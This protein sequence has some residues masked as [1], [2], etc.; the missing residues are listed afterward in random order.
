V[1]SEFV[2]A[3]V[4][5]ANEWVEA[6][7]F[8]SVALREGGAVEV[9]VPYK[10]NVPGGAPQMSDNLGI[11][12]GSVIVLGIESLRLGMLVLEVFPFG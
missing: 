10:P 4:E 1:R 3:S 6:R 11:P 2:N 5:A 8:G 7:V 12:G 9:G